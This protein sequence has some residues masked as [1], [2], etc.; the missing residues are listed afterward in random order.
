[1]QMK[2]MT[3]RLSK[4]VYSNLEVK[5]TRTNLTTAELIRE[6]L[7]QFA[8]GDE[9]NHAEANQKMETKIEDLKKELATNLDA[10]AEAMDKKAT[11]TSETVSKMDRTLGA[12]TK[13][14]VSVLPPKGV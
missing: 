5:A 8:S 7:S 2:Q 1:M 14:I 9:F 13:H 6:V 4:P 12:L 10:F 3:L 11:S